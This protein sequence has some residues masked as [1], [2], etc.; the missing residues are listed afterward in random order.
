MPEDKR[1]HQIQEDQSKFVEGPTQSAP[2]EVLKYWTPDRMRDAQPEPFDVVK[3]EQTEEQAEQKSGA[4]AAFTTTRVAN[5]QAYPFKANGK[6]FYSR[7]GKNYSCSASAIDYNV[8]LT[9]AHCTYNPTTGQWATNIMF[10][11]SYAD[12]SS[13]GVFAGL[14]AIVP[15]GWGS[16]RNHKYDYSMVR[17]SKN[18]YPTCTKLGFDIGMPVGARQLLAL[19]YPGEPIPG[20]DFN[21]KYMWQCLGSD[22]GFGSRPGVFKMENNLTGGSSGG[23]WLSTAYS[24]ESLQYAVGLNSYSTVGEPDI[25]YSPYFS[26]GVLDMYK[27]VTSF[28]TAWQ[29]SLP[30]SGYSVVS[31]LT[32]GGGLYVGSNGHVYS[33]DPSGGSVL[34]HNGLPDRGRHE[35]RLAADS[36]RLYVGINGYAVGI[37]LSDFKTSWQTSLPSSGYEV[38][39]V[40]TYGGGLYVG[41]NGHVY[42]LDPSNGKVLYHNDLPDRGRHEIRLATDGSRLYVGTNGYAIGINLS[43]FKTS[44]QTSL[45]DSGYEVASMLAYDG[46]LYAGSNGHIYSLDPSNGKVLYHNSL[47]DR[48]RH[49]IRLA[50]DP[51]RLYVGTNSYGIALLRS[52]LTTQWQREL[53]DGNSVVSVLCQDD[54]LFFGTDGYAYQLALQQGQILHENTLPDRGKHEIRLAQSGTRLFVGTNGYAIGIDLAN[55]S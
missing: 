26:S 9:A 13:T 5:V 19:G 11:S 37:N 10:K 44:W 43:D 54:N 20:Y 1:D 23:P 18:M 14:K 7:D 51:V 45:P 21:G 15:D 32:S 41:S 38:V 16:D 24:G 6:L 46:G 48:G 40:L 39:S 12:G 27:A 8:I 34:Y 35:T 55:F 42:L 30:D 2:E 3:P 31:V 29:T 47:P 17:M 4:P 22:L 28:K 53:P 33:L 49:E 50:A 52:D 36:S 25:T